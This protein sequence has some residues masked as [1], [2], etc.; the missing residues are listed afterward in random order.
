[1]R[2]ATVPLTTIMDFTLFQKPQRYIGNEW[3]VVKKTHH[4]K[5]KICVC[6]PDYYEIG[7]SNLGLRIIYG[8]LNEFEDVVCE[9][10]FMPGIDLCGFLIKNRKILFSLETKTNLNEFEVIGFNLN[11]ELN[12]INF[13]RILSLGGIVLEAKERKNT[14]VLGGAIANPEPLA[15]FVDV[16]CL[17]EFEGVADKFIEI[18][19]KYKDKESRLK[20]FS[21]IDGLY[22]PKF[23]AVN[24]HNNSF[25]FE[26]VYS[27]AQLP[28][29]KVYIKDLDS[30][31]YPL[32]W[33]VPNTS[34]IHDRVPI[35]IARG[36][37][38]ACVF[39]QAKAL[40]H[41]YR[42]RRPSTILGFMK[43]IYK[44][45]GYENFSFLALS[46]SDYSA[47]KNI[48]T[49][50]L[51][52]FKDKRIGLSL[53]SLRIDDIVGGL[54]NKIL[55]LKKTSLTVAVEAA[56]DDLRNK[57]NKNID[58]NKLFETGKI[59]RSLNL[60]HIKIYFMFGF[61]D[62]NEDDLIAIGKFLN[63]LRQQTRLELNVSINIFS[64]KPFSAWQNHALI[65]ENV[66]HSRR[67]TIL[68]NIPPHR[69]IKV[70]LSSIKKSILETIL[71]RGDRGLGPVIYRVFLKEFEPSGYSENFSWD[72]WEQA[73]K[74]EG[75]DYRFYLEAKT[76]NFPW[77]FIE[78]RSGRTRIETRNNAEDFGVNLP[79]K[80]DPAK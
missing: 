5:I 48:T 3:N 53:P 21:E 49:E 2:N 62:E 50:A 68:K 66:L 27:Y 61:H 54:Y 37:P 8:M 18:L 26:K 72:I 12:F 52:Y 65:E 41:P 1:M 60:R 16:F 24:F 55:P 78:N 38:N 63:T 35:E 79:P 44:N 9:R 22:V 23:Y 46:A 14:I 59:I 80:R 6:Y 25:K 20:G 15:D 34:I 39:C 58:I 19:R 42:E 56:R 69:G 11:Y 7:M 74:D 45:S 33:L 36:C 73:M 76:E 71:S 43:E 10:T 4:G 31:Y 30:A 77:S 17:G 13:L 40:Y 64:P 75:I 67:E 51:D 32:K 57:L 29:K 28:I 47:I 70:S